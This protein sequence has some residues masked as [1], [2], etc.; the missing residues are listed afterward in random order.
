[1][2][3]IITVFRTS[4]LAPYPVRLQFMAKTKIKRILLLKLMGY[5]RPH[6]YN[7]VAIP[8]TAQFSQQFSKLAQVKQTN[9]ISFKQYV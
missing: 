6:M 4:K 2:I 8:K 5:Y 3:F 9:R 7:C 1:M